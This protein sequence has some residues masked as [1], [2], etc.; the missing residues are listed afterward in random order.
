MMVKDREA[1]ESWRELV[2]GKERTKNLRDAGAKLMVKE[3]HH[4]REGT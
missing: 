3:G 1:A 2:C 4:C